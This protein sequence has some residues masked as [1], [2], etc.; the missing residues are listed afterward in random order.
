MPSMQR[1]RRNS[2]ALYA[3]L[4]RLRSQEMG[5]AQQAKK[6]HKPMAIET[7]LGIPEM[8]RAVSKF[9]RATSRFRQ[10]EE[11]AQ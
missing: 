5:L 4:P 10:P 7:L 8:A 3:P 11:R 9:I 6:I 1:W 2:G